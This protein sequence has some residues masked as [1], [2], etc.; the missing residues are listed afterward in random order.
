MKPG[1]VRTAASLVA[2]LCVETDSGCL[3]WRGKLNRDGYGWVSINN[4]SNGIHRH[5]YEEV[6]GK[7]PQGLEL[8][9][10]CRNRACCRLSHLEPVTHREN[11]R[12]GLV[13][14]VLH[15]GFC[16]NGHPRN[17]ENLYIWNERN[18][19]RACNR[20]AVKRAKAR[21]AQETTE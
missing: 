9:H 20:A 3:E 4:R 18:F 15:T 14:N 1:D 6:A 5:L 19:C 16:R 21:R 13:A 17:D 12:R 7:V 8:D 11:V 2:A 10:L